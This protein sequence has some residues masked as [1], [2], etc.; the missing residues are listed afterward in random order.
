M[1]L[2]Q[3][4]DIGPDSIKDFKAALKGCKTVLWNGPMGVFEFDKF[5]AGTFAIAEAVAE[6]TPQVGLLCLYC[7]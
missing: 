7:T 6:L 1:T 3:G 2:W 5:T 4:L